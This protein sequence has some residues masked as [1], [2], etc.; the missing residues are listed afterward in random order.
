MPWALATPDSL[1]A[2]TDKA[3]LFHKLEDKNGHENIMQLDDNIYT[4]DGN[5]LL[6]AHTGLPQTIAELA[7][8]KSFL[9]PAKGKDIHFVT[10]IMNR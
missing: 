3:K 9:F 4:M 6:Q 2:K 7:C 10:D 8:R 5:A 1:P